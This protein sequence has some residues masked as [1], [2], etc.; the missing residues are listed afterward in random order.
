VNK[1]A[2]VGAVV[3]FLVIFKVGYVFH[4]ILAAK[5]FHDGLGPG[6]QRA[7]YFVPVIFVCFAIYFVLMAMTYP[8][9]YEYFAERRG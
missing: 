2:I 9:F 5:L 6:V 8:V 3:A 7:S 4:E 1:R